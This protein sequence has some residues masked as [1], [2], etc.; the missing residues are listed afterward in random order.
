MI[1]GTELLESRSAL[2]T[3]GD[4]RVT[5]VGRFIRKCSLDELPQLENVREGTMSLVGPRPEP[6]SEYIGNCAIDRSFGPA[7]T[8]CLPG[9]T[10]LEQINGR[11]DI[12][13]AT[14]IEL[15]KQY[16]EEACLALDIDILL[17]T[18]HSVFAADG[19]Y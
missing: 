6:W 15:I 9:L 2:K 16:A 14:R 19:A 4:D 3:T 18:A 8:A 10:G 17:K 13:Q 7:Y 12:P 11:A 1:T 5:R